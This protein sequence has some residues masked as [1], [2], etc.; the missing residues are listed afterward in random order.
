MQEKGTDHATR[1]KSHLCADLGKQ[2]I[3]MQA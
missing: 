3:V 2:V 1:V